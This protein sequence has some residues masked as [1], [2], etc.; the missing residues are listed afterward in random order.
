MNDPVKPSSYAHMASESL[1]NPVDKPWVGWGNAGINQR[2]S[3]PEERLS[4][5]SVGI[6]G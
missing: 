1:D 5:A 2:K 4:I 6:A 3:R